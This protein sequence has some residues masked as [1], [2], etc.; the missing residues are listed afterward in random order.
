MPPLKTDGPL[1]FRSLV[2]IR[3]V[4]RVQSSAPKFSARRTEAYHASESVQAQDRRRT[5]AMAD[6]AREARKVG[7]ERA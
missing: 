4:V 2:L 5:G 1:S 3:C 7:G 6:G